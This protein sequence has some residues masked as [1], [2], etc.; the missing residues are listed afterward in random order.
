MSTFYCP[1]V[2]FFMQPDEMDDPVH[3]FD[4][5]VTSVNHIAQTLHGEVRDAAHAPLSAE[6]LQAIRHALTLS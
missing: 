5:L 1:G 6:S 3:C 2:V 4:E